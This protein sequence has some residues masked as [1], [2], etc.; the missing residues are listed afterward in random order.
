MYVKRTPPELKSI[1]AVA[2]TGLMSDYALRK[3]VKAGE[4]PVVFVGRKALI[5]YSLLLSQLESLKGNI[6]SEGERK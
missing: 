2:R 4:I 3:G 6:G 5:N 1:P